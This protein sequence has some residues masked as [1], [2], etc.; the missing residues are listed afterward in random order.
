VPGTGTPSTQV[1][2][3][4]GGVLPSGLFWTVGVGRDAIRFSDNGRR[5]VFKVRD[6]PVID[7][8]QFGGANMVP[9]L[10]DF[11]VTWEA[12]GPAKTY[13]PD[14]KLPPTDPAAFVG[15]L[16]EAKSEISCSG[17]ELGFTFRGEGKADHSRGLGWAHIGSE[18]NGAF[19]T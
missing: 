9:A 8:F 3:F 2:D 14:R 7:T 11:E 6:L 1:H 16:A 15:R 5:A 12:K 19:L 17:S 18:R 13:E 4:N 10:V